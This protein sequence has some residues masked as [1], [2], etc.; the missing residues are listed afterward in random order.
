MRRLQLLSGQRPVV[1]RPLSLLSSP[2]CTRD[3]VW[4][5]MPARMA[6]DMQKKKASEGGGKFQILFA[7]LILVDE[8]PQLFS[9]SSNL[10]YSGRCRDTLPNVGRGSGNCVCHSILTR[11]ASIVSL[12]TSW[13]RSSEIT[14]VPQLVFAACGGIDRSRTKWPLNPT[15]DE[16]G[17]SD[18][19][20]VSGSHEIVNGRGE[21]TETN[22]SSKRYESLA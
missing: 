15:D 2:S 17:Q 22:P 10:P 9:S 8:R 1:G 13:R 20:I 16:D 5:F 14:N 3:D 19:S 4:T 11:Q 12:L 18:T 7:D 21:S 6:A